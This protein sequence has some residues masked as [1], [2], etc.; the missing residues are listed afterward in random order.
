MNGKAVA[1]S[2]RFD[3]FE[4]YALRQNETPQ[5][6]VAACGVC[7]AL[8][9]DLVFDSLKATRLWLARE[10]ERRGFQ[11][12]FPGMEQFKIDLSLVDN[13]GCNV[14]R[15]A[16]ESLELPEDTPFVR[17]HLRLLLGGVFVS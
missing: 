16:Q 2:I 4:P 5:N 10:W 8:K 12:C 9:S 15:G 3:H 11:E 7:N 13:V 1:L 14:P 6:L 17:R